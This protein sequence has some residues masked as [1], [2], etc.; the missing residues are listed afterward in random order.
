MEIT[1]VKH[2]IFFPCFGL[3]LCLSLF[4]TI[5]WWISKIAIQLIQPFVFIFCTLFC[6]FTRLNPN[7]IFLNNMKRLWS[8]RTQSCQVINAEMWKIRIFTSTLVAEKLVIQDLLE[9]KYELV[10]S[11][12]AIQSL[13]HELNSYVA[14]D[15]EIE[16]FRIKI[17][18]AIEHAEAKS[19]GNIY[20]MRVRFVANKLGT[21]EDYIRKRVNEGSGNSVSINQT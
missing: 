2:I 1:K 6:T 7:T 12:N 21:S 5:W 14:N 10:D 3:T 4:T 15:N 19:L 18:I 13:N 11:Q 8:L 16:C 17:N 9:L 20:K